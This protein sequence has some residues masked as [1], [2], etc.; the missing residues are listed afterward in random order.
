MCIL[1]KLQAY[2]VGITPIHE[3]DPQVYQKCQ[4]K[5]FV[6]TL[7][8]GSPKSAFQ[9]KTIQITYSFFIDFDTT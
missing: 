6:W 4:K 9:C 3:T 8:Q 5:Y 1:C 7:V 2:Q